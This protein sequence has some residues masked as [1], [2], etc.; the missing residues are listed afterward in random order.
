MF[1]SK[2]HVMIKTCGRTTLL[3]CLE[4]ILKLIT[5]AGFNLVEVSKWKVN[6]IVKRQGTIFDESF[7]CFN[8]V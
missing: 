6:Y 5:E 7:I 4:P 8:V 3:N 1:V 2:N